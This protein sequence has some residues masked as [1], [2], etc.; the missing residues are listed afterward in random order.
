VLG[1]EPVDLAGARARESG[2]VGAGQRALA[3]AV[4]GGQRGARANAGQQEPFK[5]NVALGGRLVGGGCGEQSAP[6]GPGRQDVVGEVVDE[7]DRPDQQRAENLRVQ[8][9]GAVLTAV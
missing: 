2:Y 1:G 4:K 5:G 6:F 7:T 8:R 9:L 3:F